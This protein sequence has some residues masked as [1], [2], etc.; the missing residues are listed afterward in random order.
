MHFQV[1]DNLLNQILKNT[2]YLN[3]T[4]ECSVKK[5]LKQYKNHFNYIT[6]HFYFKI[7]ESSYHMK[8]GLF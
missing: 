6:Y 4:T 5:C 3:K 7:F 1:N 2:L 8:G